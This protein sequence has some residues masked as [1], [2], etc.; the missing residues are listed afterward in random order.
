MP[1]TFATDNIKIFYDLAPGIKDVDVII[2]LRIQLERI[3]TC[4]ISS[5][6]DYY[7]KYG[8]KTE[9]LKYAKPHC[10]IFCIQVQLTVM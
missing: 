3:K 4:L 8:I 9:L 7:Y 6:P 1:K 10:F 5:L 2:T